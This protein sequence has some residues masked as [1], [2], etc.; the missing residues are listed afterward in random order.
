MV[1]FQYCSIIS[2]SCITPG[3]LQSKMLILSTNVDKKSLETEFLIAICRPTG[4]KWQ[5]KTLFL[6]NFYPNLLIV[7]SVFDCRLPGV[8]M[9]LKNFKNLC[10]TLVL[11]RFHNLHLMVLQVR[12]KNLIFLFLIQNICWTVSMRPFFEHPKQMSKLMGKKIFTILQL[13]SYPSI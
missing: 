13:F 11:V 2:I 8:C 6:L 7:K 3:R 5:T 10:Q 1:L 4:D 9:I 12:N